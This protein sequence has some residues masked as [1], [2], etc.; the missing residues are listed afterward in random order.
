MMTI[1][2][3]FWIEFYLQ[4]IIP[5]IATN[6]IK[7]KKEIYFL[8]SESFDKF[9]IKFFAEQFFPFNILDNGIL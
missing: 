3:D 2:L 6:N 4:V 7:E 5:L 1:N 8:I 9:E